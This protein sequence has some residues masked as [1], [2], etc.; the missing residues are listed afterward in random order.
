MPSKRAGWCRTHRNLAIADCVTGEANNHYGQGSHL[1]TWHWVPF[2]MYAIAIMT[3]HGSPTFGWLQE[4]RWCCLTAIVSPYDLPKADRYDTRSICDLYCFGILSGRQ[5]GYLAISNFNHSKQMKPALC[6]TSATL[7][8]CAR[9]H[10][11][12]F[13]DGTRHTCLGKWISLVLTLGWAESLSKLHILHC[14]DLRELLNCQG[15]NSVAWTQ[16]SFEMSWGP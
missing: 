11:L 16:A 12:A 15:L 6:A 3:G 4:G 8:G 5:V 14:L 9:C 7:I 10:E 13:G 1:Y 2:W